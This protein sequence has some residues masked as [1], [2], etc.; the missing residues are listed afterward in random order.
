MI[1]VRSNC[2]VW[3]ALMRKYVE[4][5]IGH[6]TPAGTKQNDPSENT[7]EFS[8][9]KKLSRNGTTEPRYRR[10]K[11]GCSRTASENE[12]KITPASASLALNVVTTDTESMTASTATPD[13][14]S[15]SAREMPS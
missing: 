1:S 10:T 6:R 9:A 12:Q 11:S 8:A 4:S 5:S 14:R 13:S 15:C 2:P 7:A 3:A